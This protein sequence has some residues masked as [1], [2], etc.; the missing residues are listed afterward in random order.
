VSENTCTGDFGPKV[1]NLHLDY[2]LP[3]TD[4]QIVR[5]GIFWPKPGEEGADWIDA[6]DHH[7]VWYDL[8]K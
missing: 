6:T 7:M 1:G 8:T 2:V 5:N 4:F 3:S